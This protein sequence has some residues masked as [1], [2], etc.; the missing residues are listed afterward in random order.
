MYVNFLCV[1]AICFLNFFSN[2]SLFGKDVPTSQK[3]SQEE[4]KLS[5]YLLPPN[6]PV[7][8]TLDKLF[9]DPNIF[10][11]PA[12]LI[13][14]GFK[15]FNHYAENLMVCTHPLLNDYVIKK[16]TNS[17]KPST[18][19]KRYLRRIKA[20]QTTARFIKTNQI[21]N[22]II[23][24]KYLY[25]LPE[26]FS[27]QNKPTYL[28]IADKID[29]CNKKE[30]QNRYYQIEEQVLAELCLFVSKFRGL[31]SS[32]GNLP[33]TKSNKIAFIDL[34]KWEDR[35]SDEFLS[36]VKHVLNIEN[37]QYVEAFEAKYLIKP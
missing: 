21:E 9:T 23:P 3:T 12:Y 7:Q 17:V 19:L 11:H 20:A 29:L 8:A 16:F 30:T 4:L 34:D 1:L 27:K 33:F 18:Q 32:I 14:A 22:L 6:H 35:R 10:D 5:K 31:D 36:Q 13:A 15:F 26:N 2:S 24:K 25:R 37:K 28:L